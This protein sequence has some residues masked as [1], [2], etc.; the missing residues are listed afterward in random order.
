M[1]TSKIKQKALELGYL[2]CGV[3]P[4]N[5]FDEYL[6]ELDR[7]VSL[8]PESEE[9]YKPFYGFARQPENAKSVIVCTHRVNNYRIPDSLSR[10]I[11]KTYLFDPRI[12]YSH[13]SR[14]ESEFETYITTLGISVLKNAPVPARLAAAK[15]GLGK[16]GRNCFIYDQQHGS[17]V[18]IGT[19][20]VDKVLEYDAI[21][22]DI[23]MSVCEDG[24]QKCIESC[25]TKALSGS[26]TMDR[27]KCVTQLT[28]WAK[29]L[30]DEKTRTQLGQWLYGCDACQ[31][32][33]P[34]NKGKL[35]GSE[36]YP[37]LGVY[38]EYL[39]PERLFE[40]DAD[41]Y[42]NIINPRFWYVGEDGLWLWRCNALRSMINSGDKKYHS[43]IKQAC[44][45]E[46]E[47]VREIAQ[48]AS[49]S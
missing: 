29:D 33:C 1:S 27:G 49:L 48:S 39:K 5:I 7:R 13:E 23:G 26:L 24:C 30:P 8:F 31:D 41:T 46:D 37:L 6:E 15:A 34:A 45:H 16:Y 3:I 4:V 36:E 10:L 19:W 25:P 18:W 32:A 17:Y 40:M 28:T 42:V 12:S 9:L 20:V 38:E 43:L 11:G 21:E 22:E 2:A 44:D 47:R 14:L 35:N